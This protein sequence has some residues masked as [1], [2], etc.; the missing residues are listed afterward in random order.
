AGTAIAACAS[1]NGSSQTDGTYVTVTVTPSQRRV[2]TV[3]LSTG[4]TTGTLSISLANSLPVETSLTIIGQM[5]GGLGAAVRESGPRTDGA[6]QGQTSSTWPIA[7]GAT[8]TPPAQG[9]RV[10]SFV[11]EAAAGTG[12]QTSSWAG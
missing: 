3:P 6:H 5:G 4:A 2:I 12:T 9:A 10:R 1:T 8:F 7:N 11:A